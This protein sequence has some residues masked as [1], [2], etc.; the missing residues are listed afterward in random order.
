M[1][2]NKAK[3]E[4]AAASQKIIR[5]MLAIIPALAIAAVCYSVSVC[6]WFQASVIN[7]GNVIRT[8][9]Y[10]VA[11]SAICG[12]TQIQPS[13][14]G[15]YSLESGKIYTITLTATGG[16]TKG[17]CLIQTGTTTYYTDQIGS[18]ESLTFTFLPQADAVYAFTAR[19]GRQDGEADITDGIE[20]QPETGGA[21][22]TTISSKG[23]VSSAPTTSSIAS[24]VESDTESQ[25]IGAS[26]SGLDTTEAESAVFPSATESQQG[27]SVSEAASAPAVSTESQFSVPSGSSSPAGDEP[28]D[29]S[30]GE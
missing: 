24:S 6:A 7:T 2:W 21:I 19:W 16:A 22:K 4:K 29:N 12:E 9:E 8:V 25:P 15:T 23:E 10:A 11:V 28:Y 30:I 17:Y 1:L 26:A 20:F 3:H 27:S 5:K 18:G 13:E 14:S